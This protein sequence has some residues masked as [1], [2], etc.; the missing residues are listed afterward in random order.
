VDLNR[1]FPSWDDL[2]KTR[3]QL[4]ATRAEETQALI[5]YILD[6]PFVLGI[7]FHDGSVVTSY[8]FDDIKVIFLMERMMT[9]INDFESCS[10]IIETNTTN[11]E[12]LFK[13]ILFSG[14][15]NMQV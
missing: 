4:L 14:L 7:N 2:N 9:S 8:P 12:Q 6:N 3:E 1:S 10:V 15:A 13:N 5:K 11:N